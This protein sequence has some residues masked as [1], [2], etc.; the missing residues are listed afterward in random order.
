MPEIQRTPVSVKF[1]ERRKVVIEYEPDTIFPVEA[2]EAMFILPMPLE[3]LRRRHGDRVPKP[4]MAFGKPC[5]RAE[6][7][8]ALVELLLT[9]PGAGNAERIDGP[10]EE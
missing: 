4:R 6:D 7:L 8:V 9:V 10:L 1:N 3:E 5:L 2:L